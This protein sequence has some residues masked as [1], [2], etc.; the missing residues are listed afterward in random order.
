MAA[1]VTVG[2]RV[3]SGLAMI[4]APLL[5]LVAS[6]LGPPHTASEHL[7]DQLPHIAANPDRFLAF[8]LVGLLA[9][10]LHVPAVLGMAHLLRRESPLLALS[11]AALVVVGSLSLAVV[12][13]VQ[14]VEHQMIHRSADRDQMVA[15]LQ[16][17][18]GGLG[19]KIVLGGLLLGFFLG[20]VVLCYGFLSTRVVPRAIPIAILVSLPINAVGQE[21]LSRLFFLIG[22]GWL[23]VLVVVARNRDWTQSDLGLNRRRTTPG[24]GPGRS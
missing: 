9:V 19:L 21:L 1:A 12:Q 17:V 5:L 23:G 15:L 22:V 14:L 2:N 3:G 10:T 16:R 6:A 4:G 7:P 20:W 8:T 24:G 13:G 18:E 11:G